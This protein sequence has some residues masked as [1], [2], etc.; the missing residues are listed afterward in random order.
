MPKPMKPKRMT[1]DKWFDTFKPKQNEVTDPN[2][3]SH[4]GTMYETY[5]ADE[6]H[7]RAVSQTAPNTVWT[8]LDV[9]KLIIVPG[10]HLVDRFAYFITEVPWKPEQENL[11]I[12]AD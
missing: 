9:G 12:K 2:R 4:G 1:Y 10:W 5:G 8:I 7:I 11:Q 6:A 3:C